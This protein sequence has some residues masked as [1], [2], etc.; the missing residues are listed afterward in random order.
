MCITYQYIEKS[1][2]CY[3]LNLYKY[4]H[5]KMCSFV[6]VMECVHIWVEYSTIFAKIGHILKVY[7]TFE[8]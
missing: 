8:F 5:F 2:T 3:D 4:F 6:R 1:I 7:Q